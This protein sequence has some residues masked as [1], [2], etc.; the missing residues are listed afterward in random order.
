MLYIQFFFSYNI[1]ILKIK[2]KNYQNQ[3]FLKKKK[4]KNNNNNNNIII[5]FIIIVVSLHNL[6][7][8]T[9]FLSFFLV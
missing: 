1:I 5:I 4:K 6:F 8:K 7:H 2:R 9:N 3:M